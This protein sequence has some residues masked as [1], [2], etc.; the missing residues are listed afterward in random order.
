M[1][2][3]LG[4]P[5]L[6]LCKLLKTQK[7][8]GWVF[9]NQKIWLWRCIKGEKQKKKVGCFR[10]CLGTF[11]SQQHNLAAL[12]TTVCVRQSNKRPETIIRL[13]LTLMTREREADRKTRILKS[14][15]NGARQIQ[16]RSFFCHNISVCKFSC[17]R[18]KSVT[19]LF[20]SSR[21]AVTN[22]RCFVSWVK[23]SQISGIGKTICSSVR[24]L[25]TTSICPV[26]CE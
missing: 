17:W 18:K 12:T 25:R 15:N 4:Q 7:K 22:T 19:L 11:F 5:T 3:T 13:V 6:S 23:Y 9:N 8:F 26:C 16:P 2:V 1:A 21:S 20:W 14:D 10:R 24:S